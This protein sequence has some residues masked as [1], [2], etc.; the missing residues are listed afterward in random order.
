MSQSFICFQS[1]KEMLFWVLRTAWSGNWR[2]RVRCS[3]QSWRNWPRA[4]GTKHF[5]IMCILF[6]FNSLQT[7]TQQNKNWTQSSSCQVQDLHLHLWSRFLWL[8]KHLEMPIFRDFKL[9][10]PS[11]FLF[12]SAV[13]YLIDYKLLFVNHDWQSSLTN[14]VAST[15]K[16]K[17]IGQK[18]CEPWLSWDQYVLFQISELLWSWLWRLAYLQLN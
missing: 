18:M 15:N 11:L 3:G 16:W 8:W 13:K 10:V 7:Q 5:Q 9:L 14:E 1:E 6:I 2:R 4:A 12:C 17:L